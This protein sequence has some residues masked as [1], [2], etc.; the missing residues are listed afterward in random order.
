M[1]GLKPLKNTFPFITVPSQFRCGC[2]YLT[3]EDAKRGHNIYTYYGTE[4]GSLRWKGCVMYL[5]NPYKLGK[6]TE[7]GIV[8]NE[9][10]AS[11]LIKEHWN[12]HKDK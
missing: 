8:S 1:P 4:Y 12:K 5:S 10:E 2:Y 7:I 9:Y 3:E 11:K 6:T